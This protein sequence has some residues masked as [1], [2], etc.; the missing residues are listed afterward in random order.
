MSP[1]HIPVTSGPKLVRALER[2]GWE[3]V[4]TKGDHAKLRKGG[5]RVV[6]PLHKELKRGTTIGILRQA[7]MSPQELRDLL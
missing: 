2:A 4:S 6:V 1:S 7:G 5:E 3:H